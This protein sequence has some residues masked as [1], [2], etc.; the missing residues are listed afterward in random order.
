VYHNV[1]L[2]MGGTFA[3]VT[4]V[5]LYVQFWVGE[6]ERAIRDRLADWYVAIADCDWGDL[7]TSALR[8]TERYLTY[9]FGQRLLSFRFI[10]VMGSISL[11]ANIGIIERVLLAVGLPH[12]SALFVRVVLPWAAVNTTTDVF[13][14]VA[15]RCYLRYALKRGSLRLWRDLLVMVGIAYLAIAAAIGAGIE[16]TPQPRGGLPDGVIGHL[17][18]FGVAL[19]FLPLFIWQRPH[20]SAKSLL[21]LTGSLHLPSCS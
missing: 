20:I 15:S 2:W 3:G 6:D 1:F 19:L 5:L 4:L 13:A 7:I 11:I 16:V 21:V 12:S 18:R 10:A 8:H 17:E 14:V 9:L